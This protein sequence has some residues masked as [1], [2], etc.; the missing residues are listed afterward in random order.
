LKSHLA[1]T[2][3]TAV[4][5]TD[6]YGLTQGG[7]SRPFTQQIFITIQVNDHKR[8]RHNTPVIR[9]ANTGTQPAESQNSANRAGTVVVAAALPRP[10]DTKLPDGTIIHATGW[11]V[12]IIHWWRESRIR[13][14]A[15]ASRVCSP[16]IKARGG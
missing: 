15:A 2:F 4:Q 6:V 12:P 14:R 3:Q 8:A 1:A 7:N 11:R 10:Q 13:R 16:S 9:A 5:I